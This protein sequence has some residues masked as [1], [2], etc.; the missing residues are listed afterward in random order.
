MATVAYGPLD[1]GVGGRL[2][3][4]FA[5]RGSG[6]GTQ[7]LVGSR[8]G[9]QVV[10]FTTTDGTTFNPTVI[11]TAPSQ[12]AWLDWDWRLVLV[13]PFGL[14]PAEFNSAISPSTSLPAP[15][16]APDFCYWP[17]RHCRDLRGPH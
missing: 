4:T 13:T 1:P 9:T 2:G 17:K 12:Q 6:T 15:W 10:M 8:D 14:N 3:D 16:P 5:V 7:I 11:D